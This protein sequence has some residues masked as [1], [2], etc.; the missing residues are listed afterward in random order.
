MVLQ[1]ASFWHRGKKQL[2][3]GQPRSQGLSSYRPAP[4]GNEVGK[5]PIQD[6][7]PWLPEVPSVNLPLTSHFFRPLE[8]RS[9]TQS[10]QSI[11]WL[12]IKLKFNSL[13][14]RPFHCYLFVFLYDGG[15]PLL[16]FFC[17]FNV[18]TPHFFYL[19]KIRG[20][21]FDAFFLSFHWPRAQHVTCKINAYK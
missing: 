17:D 4:P 16:L 1:E 8:S 15:V 12:H 2:G 6:R 11:P 14:Q 9:T 13:N 3:N 5:W 21:V 10:R 19:W 18:L 20:I 7:V